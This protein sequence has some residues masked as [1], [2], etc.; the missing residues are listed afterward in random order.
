M[1][2]SLDISIKDL[3]KSFKS[4]EEQLDPFKGVWAFRE[5]C[6]G[7]DEN[8]DDA[9][10]RDYM[11]KRAHKP[12]FFRPTLIHLNARYDR[13]SKAWY[14]KSAGEIFTQNAKRQ[15]HP[16]MIPMEFLSESPENSEVH[17]NSIPIIL[18][19]DVTGSMGIFA[20]N[21]SEKGLPK[22]MGGIIQGGVPDRHYFSWE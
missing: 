18:G 10:K 17:T 11:K 8:L 3:P 9:V 5:P 21:S 15:A 19:L 20:P 14:T 16:S 4:R 13:A 22:L 6:S 12:D 2:L 1:L 7:I